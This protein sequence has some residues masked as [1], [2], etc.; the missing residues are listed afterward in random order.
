VWGGIWA[1]EEGGGGG[2]EMNQLDNNATALIFLLKYFSIF[3]TAVTCVSMGVAGMCEGM[4][5]RLGEVL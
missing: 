2:G 3:G 4:V 5:G 1:R